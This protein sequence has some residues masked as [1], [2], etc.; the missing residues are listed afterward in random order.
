[1]TTPVWK[2]RLILIVGLLENLLFS[3]TI[4]GWTALNYML[5]SEGVYQYVC[6]ENLHNNLETAYNATSEVTRK[7]I[8]KRNAG[9][10][11]NTF[12]SSLR[13]LNKEVIDL[14][15]TDRVV[16]GTNKT[17]LEELEAYH[18]QPSFSPSYVSQLSADQCLSER[19]ISNQFLN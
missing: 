13:R 12:A 3:G 19:Q 10:E 5:K 2:K 1:M 9:D 17:V 14:L 15:V 11:D 18:M 7:Q 8:L 4:F 6:D 16:N